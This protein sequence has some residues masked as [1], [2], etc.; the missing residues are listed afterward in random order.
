VAEEEEQ[1]E[2]PVP[3]RLEQVVSLVEQVGKTASAR[4]KEQS[5]TAV[6]AVVF[7]EEEDTQ[8]A[9]WVG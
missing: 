6:V 1:R 5:R 4:L 2:P 8:Q 7:V 9:G 3:Q